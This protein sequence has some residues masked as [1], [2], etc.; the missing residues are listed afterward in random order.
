MWGVLVAPYILPTSPLGSSSTAE[1]AA[2][3]LAVSSSAWAGF[4]YPCSPG[5]E[6]MMVSQTTPAP[7]VSR[8]SACMLPVS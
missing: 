5:A 8:C 1:G 6:E 2:L 4:T 7:V 3:R